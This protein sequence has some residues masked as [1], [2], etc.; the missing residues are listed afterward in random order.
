LYKKLHL[1][2]G[3]AQAGRYAYRILPMDSFNPPP[4]LDCARVLAYALIDKSVVYSEQGSFYVDGK[5]L[6]P[7]PR[8]AICQYIDSTEILILHCDN[9]WNSLG[10]QG[11]HTS[12]RAAKATMEKSYRGLMGKWVDTSITEAEARAFLEKEFSDKKCSFC[13]RWPIHVEQM[14][15]DTVRICNICIKEFYNLIYTD[16]QA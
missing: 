11:A 1:S 14:I 10:A 5:L 13:G 3:A 2:L 4:V 9:D 12:I 15:G 16:N 8:L 7:V 6:G